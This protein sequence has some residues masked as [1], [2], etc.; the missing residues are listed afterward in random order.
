[1]LSPLTRLGGRSS[2]TIASSSESQSPQQMQMQQLPR[3]TTSASKEATHAELSGADDALASSNQPAAAGVPPPPTAAAA[4]TTTAAAAAVVTPPGRPGPV[5]LFG[6]DFSRPDI[7]VATE[8]GILLLW[9]V[10]G[11]L[12]TILPVSTGWTFL[13]FCAGLG[14]FGA[15]LRF[16]FAPLNKGLPAHF[17]GRTVWAKLGLADGAFPWGTFIVN[18]GGTWLLAVIMV[19]AKFVVSYHDHLSLALLYGVGTGFC[20][21]LTTMSTFVLELH[22]LP[23]RAGYIYGV[24]SFFVAQVGWGIIF[25]AYAMQAGRAAANLAI[26]AP[27]MAFC[28]NFVSVCNS[29]LTHVNCSAVARTS[30]GCTDGTSMATWVGVCACGTFDASVRVQ[31]LLIDSQARL[32]VTGSLVAVWPTAGDGGGG[33]EPETAIDMCISFQNLCD[34]TLQRINCPAPL[35]VNNPCGRLGISNFLGICECGLMLQGDTRVAE[36]I[37]DALAYR[38]YDMLPYGGYLSAPVPASFCAIYE[39]VCRKHLS[40]VQCPPSAR[41]VYSCDVPGDLTTFNG[42]CACGIN[43]DPLPSGRLSEVIMDSMIKPNWWPRM[44]RLSP[45]AAATA[46][47]AVV[48]VAQYDACGSFDALCGYFMEIFGCPAAAQTVQG[49]ALPTGVP[50]RPFVLDTDW[51]GLCMCGTLDA[52]GRMGEYVFDGILS[53]VMVP[54]QYIPPPIAPFNLLVASNPF[55]P[56]LTPASIIPGFNTP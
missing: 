22:R 33:V 53:Y 48:S 8:C 12:V 38:R 23:R 35:R 20:G 28:P 30:Q 49:C 25:D 17:P 46:G 43:Y 11:L 16:W 19:L 5:L 21:C 56:L 10:S 37:I 31:E 4:A 6:V 27:T 44:V 40:H 15:Y 24:A 29:L 26:D 54:Y 42:V 1:M 32:N 52:S 9:L 47:G 3:P 41:T 50:P 7:E 2:P 39:D 13:A 14:A 18:M 36:L 34:H 55:R 45:A 51:T